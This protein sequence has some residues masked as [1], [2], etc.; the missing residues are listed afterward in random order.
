MRELTDI[1]EFRRLADADE[2]FVIW[3]GASW[4][5]PCQTMDSDAL[6]TAAD[7]LGLSLYHCDVDAGRAVAEACLIRK[8][9]T[10]VAYQEGELVKKLTTSNTLSAIGFLEKFAESF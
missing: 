10:F 8:I 9:P 1:R 6:A 7:R 2:P 3:F 4:C 5:V